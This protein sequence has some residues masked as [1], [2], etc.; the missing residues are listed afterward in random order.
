MAGK[1]IHKTIRI[2]QSVYDY[3]MSFDGK[4]FSQCF[5][6]M[7]Y[8]FRDADADVKKRIEAQNAKLDRLQTKIDSI[9]NKF[10]RVDTSIYDLFQLNAY[11][12]RLRESLDMIF[13]D[14]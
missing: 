13:D 4:T 1:D 11:A 3:I 9:E 10:D 2:D 7:I 14:S 8:L 5:D 6:T 12:K